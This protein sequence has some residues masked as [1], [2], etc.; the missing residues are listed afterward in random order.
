M[1]L[2]DFVTIQDIDTSS[3]ANVVGD[4]IFETRSKFQLIVYVIST[5]QITSPIRIDVIKGPDWNEIDTNFLDKCL[6]SCAIMPD[7]FLEEDT[8][9]DKDA[10][11]DEIQVEEDEIQDVVHAG[12]GVKELLKDITDEHRY[13]RNAVLTVPGHMADGLFLRCTGGS[14]D[15]VINVTT[16]LVG[17]TASDIPDTLPSINFYDYGEEQMVLSRAKNAKK[18]KKT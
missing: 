1:A 4:A 16:L 13:G 11:A 15:G 6:F 5:H 2:N 10:D 7:M 17:P 9:T 8:D 3:P 12:P 18:A 14:G